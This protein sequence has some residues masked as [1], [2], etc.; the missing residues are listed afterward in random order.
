MLS[1]CFEGIHQ[2]TVMNQNDQDES[3]SFKKSYQE[4]NLEY[5]TTI[6]F[7]SRIGPS[8]RSERL[9]ERS[10]GLISQLSFF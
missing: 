3:S 1:G 4:I 7:S 8:E 9:S 6:N 2:S 5:S 10:E